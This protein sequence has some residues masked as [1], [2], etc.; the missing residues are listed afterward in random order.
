MSV[1]PVQNDRVQLTTEAGDVWMNGLLMNGDKA[2]YAT[3]SPVNY[4][5]GIQRTASGAI[6]CVDATAGLPAG[7]TWTN[8]LPFSVLGALCISNNAVVT[9]SNG[10]PFD[11][12]GAVCAAYLPIPDLDLDFTLGILDPRITFS[13]TTNATVTGSNGLIQFAPMNLL[14]F[15]EQF[16]NAAW[17]KGRLSVTANSIAA[18]DGTVTAEKIVENTA[19]D[20]HYVYQTPSLSAIGYTLSVYLKA[21]ERTFAKINCFRGTEYS[22]YVNLLTGAVSGLTGGATLTTVDVGD[23][24][25]RCALS[26]TVATAGN[27]DSGVRTS[28]NGTTDVY[29]GDGTSGIYIWGAQLEQSSTATTYNPTTVKNLLGFTENFDNA[30]WTKSNATITSGFTDIYGQPFAQKLVENT[31]TDQHAITATVTTSN[32]PF[33]LGIYAKAAERNWLFIRINDSGGTS[34]R[35]WFNLATGVVGNVGTNLTAA[36]TDVGNGWYRCSIT[37]SS[38]S[39]SSQ[40]ILFGVSNAD[41]TTSYTGDGTSGIYIFG[42]QLSDSASVDPYVYQ[43]VAAPASTAYYGPRFDYDP[44]T[45]A[46]KGLLI[47]EQRTQLL[48]NSSVLATQ[49]VTVTAAAHTLSFYGTGTVAISGTFVG[50][51]TGTG[52]YPTRSTLTFTPLVGAITLTVTGTVQFAQLEIGAFATSFIPSA[53]SQVTRAADNASMIG[54]NF[55]RWYNQTEGTLFANSAFASIAASTFIAANMIDGVGGQIRLDHFGGAY[56]GFVSVGGVPQAS[57]STAGSITANTNVK[58][59]VAYKTND[60]AAARDGGTVVTD[61]SGSLP[62]LTQLAIGSGS[63]SSYINGTIARIAYYPRRLANTELTAITN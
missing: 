37:V 29:T 18:P 35:S 26:F 46:P 25:W 41:N 28:V 13:R 42:A 52:A 19:T 30:A 45:L 59:A 60:F 31:A 1:L 17:T 38:A 10:I 15:S 4:S 32:A 44:V 3:S 9:W 48:L 39:A 54:N 33:T 22:G 40:S 27:S 43:P 6:Y 62:V 16:D 7:A 24:W 51:L 8:G 50:S 53:A 36:I 55:A 57:M 14:T 12:N 61:N 2:V 49:V 21:A 47:E 63:A 56:K 23:G 20:T 11:A 34:R 58:G 5:N